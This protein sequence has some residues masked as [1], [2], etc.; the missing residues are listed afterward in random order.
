MESLLI[1]ASKFIMRTKINKLYKYVKY[2]VMCEVIA[3]TTVFVFK[4]IFITVY[5][6]IYIIFAMFRAYVI[7]TEFLETHEYSA[8]FHPFFLVVFFVFGAALLFIFQNI[9]DMK[10]EPLKKRIWVYVF[11]LIIIAGL[12]YVNWYFSKIPRGKFEI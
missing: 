6:Y 3:Y 12:F 1:P 10:N 5:I 11:I 4:E 9:Y 8:L 7:P 2:F